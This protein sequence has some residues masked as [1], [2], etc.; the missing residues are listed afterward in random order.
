[1]SVEMGTQAAVDHVAKLT[2]KLYTA[3]MAVAKLDSE[4]KELGD[5]SLFNGC[6]LTSDGKHCVICVEGMIDVHDINDVH[7]EIGPAL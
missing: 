2:A 4:L 6:W 1:M 5:K 7:A 3:K